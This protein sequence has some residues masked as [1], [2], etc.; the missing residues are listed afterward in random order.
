MLCSRSDLI[1]YQCGFTGTTG[2]TPLAHSLQWSLHHAEV[3]TGTK[4][5]IS[6]SSTAYSMRLNATIVK[7]IISENTLKRN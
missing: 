5:F 4:V 6:V 3:K 7:I 2:V 1:S